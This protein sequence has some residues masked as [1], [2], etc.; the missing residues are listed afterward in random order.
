M[1][2]VR[3]ELKQM[4]LVLQSTHR[5]TEQHQLL[6]SLV[7]QVIHPYMCLVAP[8]RPKQSHQEGRKEEGG[9]GWNDV[10]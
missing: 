2:E 1:K 4:L 6:I 8:H 10:F 3:P 7:R 5:T 9:L